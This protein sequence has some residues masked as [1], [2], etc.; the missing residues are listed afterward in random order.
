MPIKILLFEDNPDLRSSIS[1]FLSFCDGMELMA[2]FENCSNILNHIDTHNPDILLM[3]I[4]MPIVN[5]IEGLKAVRPKYPDLPIIMLTVFEDDGNI[6]EAIQEGANGYILKQHVTTKLEEG[7]HEVLDG[8]APMSPIAAKI[9][10]NHISKV[11]AKKDY[12]LTQREKETL[13]SLTEG[14][15][16]KMIAANFN[17]SRETVCS[18]I[19]KIYEKLG[20]HSQ[21]EAVSKALK[22]RIV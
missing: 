5:G 15:S 9:V 3:D 12:Q 10:L 7:I 21:S 13:Q 4:D 2:A 18:H 17:I 8:G 22:E 19:K 6:I 16:Y 1:T 11:S 14:N 20:V